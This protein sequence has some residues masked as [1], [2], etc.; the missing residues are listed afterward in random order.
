MSDYKNNMLAIEKQIAANRMFAK[1][2]FGKPI[3][4]VAADW[5]AKQGELVWSKDAVVS[6]KVWLEDEGSQ[7][8]TK[9]HLTIEFAANG[10]SA[11][12]I[13][14]QAID[15]NMI[16]I[17]RI[18]QEEYP[19]FSELM[20]DPGI[21]FVADG[22]D[23]LSNSP[24]AVAVISKEKN[25]HLGEP[26]LT[27]WIECLESGG[28]DAWYEVTEKIANKDNIEAIKK[29]FE[30]D[31]VGEYGK[32]YKDDFEVAHCK[33]KG[34]DCHEVY[35]KFPDNIYG[36]DQH[37]EFYENLQGSLLSSLE[38]H[39]GEDILVSSTFGHKNISVIMAEDQ[40]FQ[41]GINGY[42]DGYV[43]YISPKNQED[44]DKSGEIQNIKKNILETLDNDGFELYTKDNS[45][46]LAPY[47]PNSIISPK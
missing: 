19:R 22:T 7:T 47:E 35:I 43:V 3:S 38:D 39:F 31:L 6:R 28:S 23:M 5:E 16:N 25:S 12:I 13:E 30:N 33:T 27:A 29:A 17:G 11:E 45:G 4:S 36:E 20:E 18:V 21:V 24:S 2:D 9:G 15:E 34:Q 1:Y 14:A 46:F 10:G 37:F 32:V 44:Q 42:D 8:G 40:R 26:Q 41:I